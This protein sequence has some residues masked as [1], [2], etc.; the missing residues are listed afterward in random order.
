MIDS[1]QEI[2]SVE[3]QYIIIKNTGRR[4]ALP[5]FVNLRL[6]FPSTET[7]VLSVFLFLRPSP[8]AYDGLGIN[9]PVTNTDAA[10]IAI[11]PKVFELIIL[12]SIYSFHIQLY[13]KFPDA[14]KHVCY[15]LA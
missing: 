9:A 2:Q 13:D 12:Y 6:V 14:A 1:R 3:D 15:V 7:P 8:D 5:T 10:K 4:L 11:I